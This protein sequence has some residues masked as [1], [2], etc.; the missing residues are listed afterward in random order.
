MIHNCAKI[1]PIV[2][3]SALVFMLLAGLS[4]P[5]GSGCGH[6]A[7]IEDCDLILARYAELVARGNDSAATPEIT[8]DIEEARVKFSESNRKECLGNRITDE[9]LAC[10]RSASN[11][12]GLNRCF[13]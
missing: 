13:E 1:R 10:V 11:V 4:L 7:T 5:F 8:R 6:R 3:Q 12:D 2:T 9:V